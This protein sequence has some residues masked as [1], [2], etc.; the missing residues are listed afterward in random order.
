[1]IFFQIKNFLD[2]PLTPPHRRLIV[3][4]TLFFACY[5]FFVLLIFQPFGTNEYK[6]PFKAW[7]LAGYGIII[8]SLFPLMRLLF[9]KYIRNFTIGIEIFN[10]AITLL[11]LTLLS[12]FYHGIFIQGSID[13]AHFPVFSLYCFSVW[14]VPACIFVYFRSQPIPE[15]VKAN[16]AEGAEIKG[17]SRYENF[18][19]NTDDIVYLC[20]K[21]NY[22][23][24]FFKKDNSI[25]SEIIR[26]T[27]HEV[28]NQLSPEEF[29]TIHR[30][31]MVNIRN[32]DKLHKADNKILLLSTSLKISLPVSKTYIDQIKLRLMD[33]R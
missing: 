14:V 20:S 30:S 11:M 23:Q 12:F 4:E 7:Q 17:Q 9:I 13:P 32:F 1:M 18:H 25:R 8:L 27:F 31:Y 22:V 10:L 2:S 6:H 29:T 16:I 28:K 3:K 33:Q 21:G 24:I 26:N 15:A 19:F 5:S